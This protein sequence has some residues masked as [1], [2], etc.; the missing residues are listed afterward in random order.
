M[1]QRLWLFMRPVPPAFILVCSLCVSAAAVV[2]LRAAPLSDGLRITA[3]AN[4][5]L[6]VT[7]AA[8]APAVGQLPLGSEVVDVGP[9]GMDKTWIR[10]KDSSGQEGWLLAN[11]TRRLDPAWRWSTYDAIA[12]DRLARKGDGFP[13]AVELVTFIERVVKEYT[14]AEGRAQM[15]LN[16]LRAVSAALAAIPRRGERREPYASFLKSQGDLVVFDEPGGRWLVNDKVIWALHGKSART[17]SAEPIAWLAVT[18]GLGGECEGYLPC[19]VDWRNRLEGE[20]LRRHPDGAHAPEAV[21]TITRV[22]DRLAAPAQPTKAFQ[23]ERGRD[24]RDLT[25]S[26]DALAKAV[27]VAQVG[28]KDAALSG[29]GSLK[30]LC[31]QP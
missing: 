23:F 13:A 28:G 26:V 5:T 1:T 2:G 24:C 10:V 25:T 8:G 20:Y 27:Q 17:P 7:P 3:A 21:E 14:N 12:E 6:R 11:L 4:V 31:G 18:N 29:L 19:Y 22:V 30:R 16:H 9:P 15:E